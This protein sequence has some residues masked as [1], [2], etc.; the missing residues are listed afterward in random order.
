M[1][2]ARALVESPLQLL[3][4]VEAAHAG[5]L[6][7]SGPGAGMVIHLRRRVPG[8]AEAAEGIAA[9]GLPPGAAI[10][11]GF[12]RGRLRSGRLADELVVGDAFSGRV[13]TMLA[14]DRLPER[15]VIVDDGLAT[16]HLAQVLT[17][18]DGELVRLGQQVTPARRMVA[19]R[20]K[21]QLLRLAHGG[22]LTVL[23]ALALE[24]S[25]RWGLG[26]AGVRVLTHT[27]PWTRAQRVVREASGDVREPVVVVGSAFVADG[28]V[29]TDPYVAW[30]RAQVATAEPGATEPGTQAVPGGAVHGGAMPDD[31]GSATAV[32]PRVCYLPHRRQTP[33]V[34]AALRAT[35]GLRVA[36][37]GL[38]VELRLAGLAAPQRVVSLPTTALA[39]LPQVL[40]GTG[41]PVTATVPPDDWWLP[42]VP[43]ALR[44]HLVEP[45]LAALRAPRPGEPRAEAS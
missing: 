14:T 37:S 16:L 7:R 36:R 1:S 44:A 25:A 11:D 23:T 43:P 20:A 15:L 10:V 35:P 3:L 33:E 39:L 30:V 32:G 19:R 24:P 26:R 29:R 28:L 34:L 41:V 6:G 31:A 21:E 8:L 18:P 42:D 2:E 40:A 9:L 17:D 38:P 5:V 4:A 13:Q 45:A 22:R 27:L 12:P